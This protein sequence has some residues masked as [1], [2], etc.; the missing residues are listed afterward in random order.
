[1]TNGI[2]RH[3]IF[4]EAINTHFDKMDSETRRILL[5]VNEADQNQ[6]LLNL[7]SKLYE[8]IVGKVDNIEFGDIPNTKGD[9]TKLPNYKKIVECTEI[10]KDIL[11]EYKQTEKP[12]LTIQQTITNLVSRKELFEKAYRFNTELP[13]IVYNTIS[14]AVV[15]S[16]SLLISTC[17]DF[18]KL[19]NQDSFQ[20][21]LDRV[22][23]AKTQQSLLFSNLEKF[24]NA[25]AKGDIDSSFNHLINNSMDK[26]NLLGTSAFVYGVGGIA[27]GILIVGALFSIVPI[28][29]ELIFYYYYTR[30]RVSDY[31]DVQAD[32]LQINANNIDIER[33]KDDAKRKK[34]V[35]RQIQIAGMFRKTSE[36]IAIDAKSSELKATKDLVVEEKKKYKA[37]DVTAQM[38]DSAASALF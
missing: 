19:P 7:T 33:I 21:S 32:L 36:K 3:P 31:F 11:H 1:M 29:R 10:I 20:I 38:P 28:I 24:N 16:L 9:F 25:C 23:Y 13:I 6:I 2:Y 26:K 4:E 12:I 34:I 8:N 14:L 30:T 18:I 5:T 27:T 35:E 37:I 22:S 15:S 17:I